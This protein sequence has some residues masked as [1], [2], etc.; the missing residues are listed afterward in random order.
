MCIVATGIRVVYDVN[1]PPGSR[2]VSARVRC[3]NCTLPMYAPLNTSQVY[4]VIMSSYLASGG[5]GFDMFKNDALKREILGMNINCTGD[6]REVCKLVKNL[7]Y[8]AYTKCHLIMM[9]NWKNI[10]AEWLLLDKKL[11]ISSTKVS[12]YLQDAKK[13]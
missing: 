1:K 12:V 3:G 9:C 7:I 10:L 8:Y 5:D 13:K 6:V 4:T 11:Y 2:L